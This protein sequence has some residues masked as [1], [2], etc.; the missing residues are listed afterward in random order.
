[1]PIL[2]GDLHLSSSVLLVT[3]DH[4]FIL[5]PVMDLKSDKLAHLV[6]EVRI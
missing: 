4:G 5:S 6:P 1:M 2:S 3:N